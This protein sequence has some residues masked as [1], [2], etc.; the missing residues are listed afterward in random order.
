MTTSMSKTDRLAFEDAKRETSY[1]ISPS[2]RDHS[3]IT[4]V[5]GVVLGVICLAWLFF[6]IP[7][8]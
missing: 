7:R 5:V 4:T 1:A 3:W 6:L 2:K 8:P